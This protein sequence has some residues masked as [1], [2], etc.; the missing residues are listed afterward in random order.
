MTCSVSPLSGRRGRRRTDVRNSEISV[1]PRLHCPSS[2]YPAP[3]RRNG[4]R[5]LFLNP[6]APRVEKLRLVSACFCLLVQRVGGGSGLVAHVETTLISQNSI[7]TGGS[8]TFWLIG[9]L[10]CLS[11]SISITP[12]VWQRRPSFQSVSF[13]PEPSVFFFLLLRLFLSLSLDLTH[14]VC[15]LEA[16]SLSSPRRRRQFSLR[17]VFVLFFY[18]FR[19]AH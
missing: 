13:L 4:R 6:L 10:A 14:F 3:L 12:F 2:E 1:V 18:S 16:H 7:L 11:F 8:V 17:N 15:L 9:P 5:R 19:F